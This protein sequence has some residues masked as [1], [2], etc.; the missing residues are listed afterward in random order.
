[1]HASMVQANDVDPA[2]IR[3][4]QSDACGGLKPTGDK[5]MDEDAVDRYQA[6]LSDTAN[7]VRADYIAEQEKKNEPPVDNTVLDANDARDKA[8][9]EQQMTREQAASKKLDS[10]GKRC[11]QETAE[12]GETCNFSKSKD[13]QMVLGMANQ[14]KAQIQTMAMT[15]PAAMCS[16]MGNLSQ[17][18]DAAVAAFSGYCTTAYTTCDNACGDD[19]ADLKALKNAKPAL[20][21][22]QARIEEA[23]DD[24]RDNRKKCNKL[25]GN[26]QNVFQNVGSYAQIEAA[27]SQYCGEKTDALAAL[28]K[29][30]PGNALCKN[31]GTANCADPNVATSSVVCICQKNPSDPRCGAQSAIGL[32][33]GQKTGAVA[34]GGA[35]DAADKSGD[36]GGLGGDGVGGPGFEGNASNDGGG[37]S[38]ARSGFGGRGGGL[39]MGGGQGG[40]K[41]GSAAGASTG[42]NPAQGTK[43]ISGYGVG[44]GGSA[45]YRSAGSGAAP[46]AQ[47][48][49]GGRNGYYG[50]NGAAGKPVDLSKFLPGGSMDPRRGLAGV[51]GPDGITGPNSDIWKKIQMR[52]Y[53]VSPSLLP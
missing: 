40:G 25:A 42:A 1:M 3:S 19:E 18:M 51:S 47:Q 52:Y 21:G 14:M 9:R 16:K 49:A 37:A 23:E 10:I 36:F 28:C 33:G 12:A 34:G 30:Q 44:G 5:E 53:S 7:Q 24:I 11:E 2:R 22:L 27:K 8:A 50:A 35:A 26:I 15:S 48:G 17:A 41:A 31:A 38:S 4:A 29:S 6:C 32:N 39:D 43:I 13:A 45:G 20:V 46:G